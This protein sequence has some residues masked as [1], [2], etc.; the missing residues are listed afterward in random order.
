MKTLH[1]KK[2]AFKSTYKIYSNDT[3]VGTLKEN[4]WKQSASENKTEKNTILKQRV[5][6]NRKQ[7]LYM[8]TPILPWVK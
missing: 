3:L 2:G 1:W 8:P 6:L 4:V 7:K 5:S